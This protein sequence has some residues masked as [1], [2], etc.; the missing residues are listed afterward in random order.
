MRRFSDF[1]FAAS[2]PG[3]GRRFAEGGLWLPR[4]TARIAGARFGISPDTAPDVA[5]EML[6]ENRRN[7]LY[8]FVIN[9]TVINQYDNL[10]KR[11]NCPALNREP[12]ELR[13]T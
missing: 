7:E 1:V 13:A 4:R 10:T 6:R 2:P 9:R 3:K 5:R 12:L 8:P 11:L